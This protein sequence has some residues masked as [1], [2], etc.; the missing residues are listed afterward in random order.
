MNMFKILIPFIF[1]LTGFGQSSNSL[2]TIIDNEC[3]KNFSTKKLD[4]TF[5]NFY[6]KDFKDTVYFRNSS[7]I[8]QAQTTSPLTFKRRI[9]NGYADGFFRVYSQ[10]DIS[11]AWIDGTY[12]NGFI[13]A[14]SYLEYYTNG[15]LKLT[16]QFEN[17]HRS[18]VW[19]WYF[20]N[21]KINRIVI[22]EIAEP[23]KEMKLDK[24]GNII[25][26]YDFIKEKTNANNK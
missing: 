8:L 21:E 19:T 12:S 26:E 6:I 2:R 11:N 15:K 20:E 7:C 14:G 22:Y 23:L 1:I 16:G 13:I 25:E 4:S 18:G 10:Y 24:D 3:E 9:Q 17:G 5:C